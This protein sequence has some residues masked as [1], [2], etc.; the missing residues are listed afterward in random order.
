[1][2]IIL[3]FPGDQ[4]KYPESGD[5]WHGLGE[6][7]WMFY[8]D[9]FDLKGRGFP[10]KFFDPVTGQDFGAFGEEVETTPEERALKLELVSLVLRLQE[11]K[12]EFNDE[13]QKKEDSPDP[14]ERESAFREREANRA[15]LVSLLSPKEGVTIL[16][17]PPRQFAPAP[18]P[19][20]PP[21]PPLPPP[22]SPDE[23]IIPQTRAERARIA[24]GI[25]LRT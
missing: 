16:T 11:I 23:A 1:M 10:G 18:L 24:V 2:T 8:D 17:I 5:A 6:G 22:P 15:M 13:T 20:A 19:P 14:K 3:A 4:D 9:K 21:P 7:W 25:Q 12:E